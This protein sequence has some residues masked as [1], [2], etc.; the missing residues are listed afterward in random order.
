MTEMRVSR[1]TAVA[2]ALAAAIGLVAS[3][4]QAAPA[5]GQAAAGGGPAASS[6]GPAASSGGPAASNRRAAPTVGQAAASHA[7]ATANDSQAAAAASVEPAAEPPSLSTVTRWL[8]LIDV[9]L[10]QATVDRIVASDYDLVV[11]DYIPSEQHNA[12]Y[13]MADVV[14]RLHAAPRPKLVLA[15]ADIGQAENYR[16]Y[17]QS[18]WRVGAPDWITG[19]DPDGWTGNHPVAFWRDAWRRIWLADTGYLAGIV[20][21]GFDG[22][23][24]DWIEAYSDERVLEVARDDRVDPHAE[25]L[26]WVADIAKS[27]RD[28]R[29]GFLVIGQNAAE[30]AADD[31]YLTSVDAIA[32]EQVWFDGAADNNPPGDCPLPAT[33]ADID[34]D[35]Y[36][37][38]LPPACR[39]QYE[40]YSAST[41]HV[42]TEHYLRQ[43][44][45][46]RAAGK[47]VLTVDYAAQPDNVAFVYRTSRSLG[48]VPFVTS[49]ALDQY[50]PP[51]P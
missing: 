37:A 38:S 48:Y 43:L 19:D 5:V 49:R 15:Y 39:R 36:R 11:L 51:V 40:R 30:L 12:D 18:S 24:L 16:T 31:R 22:I 17:W 29:P 10:G 7:L 3:T 41:L 33:D 4:G 14:A 28:R 34:T 9:N 44:A 20:R 23:Y 8:Y 27:A 2:G 1:R 46:A 50:L 45:L 26:R 21:A 6:G 13:P 35:A 42:S 47:V 32:Q 25:I